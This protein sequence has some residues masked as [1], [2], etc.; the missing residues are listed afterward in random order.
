MKKKNTPIKNDRHYWKYFV[1]RKRCGLSEKTIKK[2]QQAI[3][4]LKNFLEGKSLYELEPDDFNHFRSYLSD[5]TYRGKRI[6]SNTIVNTISQLK[7]FF[8]YLG[9]KPEFQE[10]IDQ[11]F[12]A[13]WNLS[14]SEKQTL[15]NIGKKIKKFPTLDQIKN[16]LSSITTRTAVNRRNR[17]LIL[18]CFLT[19]ARISAAVTMKIGLLDLEKRVVTQD[20]D[21]GVETKKRKLIITT[22][23]KFNEEYYQILIEW[24]QE[25]LNAG[26]NDDDPLF[27]VA[28]IEKKEDMLEFE[29]SNGFIKEFLSVSSAEANI[30]KLF[31]NAGY[32]DYHAHSFRDSHIHYASEMARS[33]NDLKAISMNVGHENIGI[34]LKY[35][36]VLSSND[37]HERINALTEDGFKSIPKELEEKFKSVLKILDP[38][39]YNKYYGKGVKDEL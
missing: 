23:P 29:I 7:L 20:P 13:T 26:F 31:I 16:V 25:L 9:A 5:L 35:Y 22:I 3:N 36:S 27:P 37:V 34:T 30:K 18:F 17:C 11:E 21:Q 6:S 33:P 10:V 19:G 28:A 2:T 8:E 32:G 4:H 1:Y 14:P 15:K 24:I 38:E 39:L 12:M